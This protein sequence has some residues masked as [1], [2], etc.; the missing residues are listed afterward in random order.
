MKE[1]IDGGADGERAHTSLN[2]VGIQVILITHH[3]KHTGD[4]HW[5]ESLEFVAREQVR[6]HFE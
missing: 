3:R 6:V 1:I 5:R 2:G 4:N